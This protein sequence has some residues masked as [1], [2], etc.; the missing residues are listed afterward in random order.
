[1]ND[2]DDSVN[3]MPTQPDMAATHA[4]VNVASELV[5][6]DLFDTDTA[7]CEAVRREGAGGAEAELRAFGARIGAADYLELGVLANRFPPELDTHDR[8]GHR[9]DLVRFHAA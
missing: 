6:Y 7:L 5:D 3:A 8:F 2:M 1:M 9:V 4:V